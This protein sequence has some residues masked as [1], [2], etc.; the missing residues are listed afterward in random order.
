LSNTQ[1]HL[2]KAAEY[3][4]QADKVA[5]FKHPN[6][7]K[8]QWAQVHALATLSAAHLTMAAACEAFNG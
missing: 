2:K 1:S 4:D 6:P 3:L 5:D 7:S 8:A